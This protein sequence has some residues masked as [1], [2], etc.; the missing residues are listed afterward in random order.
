MP[1]DA[2]N[3]A[4]GETIKTYDE[5]TPEQAAAVVEAAHDAWKAWRRR[6]FPSAPR[7]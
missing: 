2:V 6:R 7:R 3:P 1:I 5:M 4:T